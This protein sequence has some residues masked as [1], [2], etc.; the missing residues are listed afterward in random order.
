MRERLDRGVEISKICC[1]F[2]SLSGR[3]P[4]RGVDRLVNFFAKIV[5]RKRLFALVASVFTSRA[6]RNTDVGVALPQAVVAIN[7]RKE[8]YALYRGAFSETDL[9]PFLNVLTYGR[10]K[11]NTYPLSKL[12]EVKTREAWDGEDGQM[13]SVNTLVVL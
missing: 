6:Q 9:S 5:H 12:P 11:L 2:A 13:V 7:I 8:V 4:F 1:R 10:G 3:C